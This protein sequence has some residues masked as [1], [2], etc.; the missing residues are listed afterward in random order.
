M[1]I[2]IQYVQLM[3]KIKTREL[4]SK[5]N[6]DLYKQLKEFRTELQQ[7][8][9]AQVT[10]GTSTKLGKIKEIR[11]AIARCLTVINQFRKKFIFN[12]YK[13]CRWIPLNL[14][15]KSTRKWRKYLSLNRIN[16]VSGKKNNNN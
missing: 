10:G 5:S 8:R 3:V 6:E 9:V 14:Q 7:L 1:G 11:K 16:K 2:D 4:K 15:K 12:Q 13:N